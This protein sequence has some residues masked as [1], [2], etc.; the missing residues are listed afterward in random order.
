MRL[1]AKWRLLLLTALAC[2]FAIPAAAQQ[3]EPVT[4]ALAEVAEEDAAD[5]LAVGVD[6][7]DRMTVDVRI[8]GGGPYAFLVDTGSERT[9]I[10]TELAR[11]LRL[12]AAKRV[13]LHS[14]SGMSIVE[15]VRIPSIEVSNVTTGAIVAPAF[16]RVNLGAVGMLGIDSLRE[17]RV[18]LDFQ[19]GTMAIRPS[20]KRERQEDWGPDMIVVRARS[21]LGQLIL[22]DARIDDREVRVVIDTGAEVSVGNVAL[23]RLL[24]RRRLGQEPKPIELISVTGGKILA[25]YT[26]IEEI[27]IGGIQI[28]GMPVAFA[29]AHAFRAFG[30]TRRPALL[31]GMDA[32]RMFDRVSVDFANRTVSFLLADPRA[33]KGT[34]NTR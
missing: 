2:A 34:V 31:L 16:N 5:I 12:E 21:R 17:Q 15:T 24:T 13:R 4:T 10:S 26:T 19:A 7:N 1:A 28:M 9:A 20:S 30:L 8:G 23:R 14:M 3:T 29:D 6:R 27:R 18:L 22:T 25:D 33:A 32:L 11:T